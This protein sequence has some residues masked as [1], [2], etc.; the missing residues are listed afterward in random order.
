MELETSISS[1]LPARYPGGDSNK[2]WVFLEG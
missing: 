1:Q 2:F